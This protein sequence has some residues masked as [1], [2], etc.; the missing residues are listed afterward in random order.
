MVWNIKDNA[1]MTFTFCLTVPSVGADV[2]WPDV[3]WALRF[4]G[5]SGAS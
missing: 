3:G 4:R 1:I 2:P 5:E